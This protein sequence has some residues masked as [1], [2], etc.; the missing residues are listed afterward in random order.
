MNGTKGFQWQ[1]VKPMFHFTKLPSFALHLHVVVKA[2]IFLPPMMYL[3][4]YCHSLPFVTP[5]T[6]KNECKYQPAL[7]NNS[8]WGKAL[9]EALR[10][11]PFQSANASSLKHCCFI[12]E[13]DVVP[14]CTEGSHNLSLVSVKGPSSS[15]LQQVLGAAWSPRL[16]S[17]ET[18]M[19]NGICR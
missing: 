9:T 12:T 14:A 7:Y 3:C 19:Q 15:A 18:G 17:G 4:F 8:L 6:K 1:Q 11:L 13:G 5:S 2:G 10:D 16:G